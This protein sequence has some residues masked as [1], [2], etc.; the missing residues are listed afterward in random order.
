M[1][2]HHVTP[3]QIKALA[4]VFGGDEQLARQIAEEALEALEALEAKDGKQIESKASDTAVGYKKGRPSILAEM[5][6]QAHKSSDESILTQVLK[7]T[8]RD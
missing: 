1:H 3:E 2:I 4:D 7:G 8:Y 6:S 5:L